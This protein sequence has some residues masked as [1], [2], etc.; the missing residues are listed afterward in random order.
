[1]LKAMVTLFLLVSTGIAQSSSDGF[2]VV[3]HVTKPGA[4]LTPAQMHDAEKL[5]QNTCAVVQRDFHRSSELHPRFT[6]V[7]GAERNEVHG[8]TEIW[9]TKWNPA[10]FA[11]GVVVM[12]FQQVLTTDVIKQLAKR[13]VQ[14]SDAMIDVSELKQTH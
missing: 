4:S 5:Y 7:L 14:Y 8:N 12:A 1:M 3:R 9:L 10:M 2:F 13:A 6:V 11:E